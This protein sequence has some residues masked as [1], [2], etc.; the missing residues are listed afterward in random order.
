MNDIN[1]MMIV[2]MLVVKIYSLIEYACISYEQVT[3]RVVGLH[4]TVCGLSVS[5][6]LPCRLPCDA[7]LGWQS[8]TI[9]NLS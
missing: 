7:F 9:S 5:Q 2:C 4:V 3:L 6:R 1:Y 8:C